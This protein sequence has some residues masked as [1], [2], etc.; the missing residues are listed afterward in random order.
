MLL[1]L[2]LYAAQIENLRL[3][4]WI[5]DDDDDDDAEVQGLSKCRREEEEREIFAVGLLSRFPVEGWEE[6]EEKAPVAERE[7]V[8]FGRIDNFI[9][10]R[11]EM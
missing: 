2:L 5:F 10:L 3:A 1:S 7:D 9:F 11:V 8:K 4:V 6:E